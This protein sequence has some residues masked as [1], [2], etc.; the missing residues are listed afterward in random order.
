[1]KILGEGGEEKKQQQKNPK[2]FSKF[3][4]HGGIGGFQQTG[5][6]LSVVL[7]LAPKSAQVIPSSTIL[8]KLCG[9]LFHSGCSKINAHNE[10]K[11]AAESAD[12]IDFEIVGVVF[13]FSRLNFKVSDC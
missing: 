2:T 9:E 7:H 8:P 4:H 1:M 3:F 5:F 11:R 13:F 6:T 10:R 12:V